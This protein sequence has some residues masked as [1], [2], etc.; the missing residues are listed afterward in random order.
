[1]DKRV[2]KWEKAFSHTAL[3]LAVPVVIQSLV[4]ASMHI[5]DNVMIGQ[6]GEIELAAV[7]QANRISFLLQITMFGV[8]S[9]LAVFTAQYWGVR[10]IKGIRSTLGLGMITALCVAIIFALAAILFPERIMRIL[11]QELPAIHA[12]SQYLRIIGFA[13][14]IEALSAVYAAVLKSTE[15]VKLPMFATSVAII[16][17]TILNYGFIFGNFG[18]PRL[19]VRGAAIATLIGVSFE[20]IMLVVFSYKNS[21]ATAARLSELKPKSKAEVKKFF[22]VVFPT[23][24]N[25]CLWSLGM[26]MYSVAYGMMGAST[27]AAVSIFNNVEQLGGVVLRGGTHACSVMTGM[28]IGA[29]HLD[30]AQLTAKRM[31][32]AHAVAGCVIG[33]I[34]VFISRPIA[35]VFN[36]AS[37]TADNAVM[38]II[39]YAITMFIAAMAS[40]VIVGILRAGGD[41]KYAMILDTAPVWL[42]GIPLVFIFG[43]GQGW[44]V[45]LVFLL[46]RIEETVKVAIGIW[47]I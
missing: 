42:I 18:F 17:N 5:V 7:T 35:S 10:D 37:E 43:P 27:V 22:R 41:V 12:G 31:I 25:E 44:P 16:S 47:R 19:G 3:R 32:F 21:F 6:L 26:V 34:L 36:V 13:Y 2:Y 28:S 9:G 46:T 11:I 20:L 15:Q 45:Y 23:M 33:A 24:I 8:V 39:I 14:I 4:A 38:I 30:E 1:M 29:G 40:A